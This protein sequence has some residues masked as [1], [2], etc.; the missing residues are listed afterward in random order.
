[1]TVDGARGGGGAADRAGGGA[2]GLCG[3]GAADI[4]PCR[5][6]VG[7]DGD[8]LPN[9][10]IEGGGLAE[11]PVDPP[12]MKEGIDIAAG[13]GIVLSSSLSDPLSLLLLKN[14]VNTIMKQHKIQIPKYSSHCKFNRKSMKCN[15]RFCKYK[16][17]QLLLP[18][19][20][21]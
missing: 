8:K 1:M 5:G 18:V 17:L 20:T 15:T 13:A 16:T 12:D 19:V 10:G 3:G 9:D 11:V 6:P 7:F 2:V 4:L 14:I 21:R